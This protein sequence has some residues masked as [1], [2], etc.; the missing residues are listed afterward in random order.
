MNNKRYAFGAAAAV[1]AMVLSA[2]SSSS[3]P[4]S[5]GSTA[6]ATGT[7][8]AAAT[9]ESIT[10]GS[11]NFQE[12]VL[13]GDI[14]ADA[15]KAKGVKVTT[16][17][18]LG[19]RQVYIP[20]LQDGSI[21]LIPEY[22]GTLLQ[23]FNKT[24]TQVSSADVLAALQTALPATL[25]V[26]DQSTAQDKDAIVV[27]KTTAAKYHLTT[28]ADLAPVAGTLT[29]GAAPEFKT[30]ADG[31]PA[32]KSIYG[33]TFGHFNALDAGGPLTINAL[34]NGTIDAGDVFTTDP[35]LAAGSSDNFIALQ[36][37]K[38]EFAAQNVLPLISKAKAT[39]TITAALNAV[40]AKLDTDTLT[41]LDVKVISDKQDPDAVAQAWLKSV[42]LA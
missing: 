27:T 15:L 22:S 12:S 6:A 13:L 37:P 3:S 10:V 1:A 19:S 5:S 14:Y 2:C 39:P 29:L 21:D 42:G 36:D 4:V 24:A 30:V 32:L 35:S 41:S 8:S 11:A 40:S 31:I 38:N 34:K 17:P 33:V 20:A 16:K 18:N 9:S 7:T 23:Y 28:I 25:Q 26:L